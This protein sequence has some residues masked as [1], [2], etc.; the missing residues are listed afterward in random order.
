MDGTVVFF[1]VLIGVPA[2]FYVLN[3]EDKRVKKEDDERFKNFKAALFHDTKFSTTQSWATPDFSDAIAL[4]EERKLIA[5][6]QG[7]KKNPFGRV[8]PFDKLVSVDLIVDNDVITSTARGSQAVGAAVGGVLLGGAGIL[9][10][11]LSAKTKSSK[12][13]NKLE[14][15]L[16]IED[17]KSPIW[18]IKFL[19]SPKLANSLE[20]K[21][22]AE[23]AEHWLGVL[24]VIVNMSDKDFRTQLAS[25]EVQTKS[26]PTASVA[27]EIVKLSALV[28]KGLLTREE[29]D[30]Q[31]QRLLSQG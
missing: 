26:I 10:G 24:S 15:K 17:L 4:D 9:L 2:A 12:M 16:T 5:L 20:F 11:G 22:A 6:I 23:D 25:T 27:D 28:E 21:A 31:K 29:F 30:S 19:P 1:L 14:L 8:F 13:I 7:T 18:V 3:Q